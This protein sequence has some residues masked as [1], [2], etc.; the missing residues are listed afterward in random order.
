MDFHYRQNNIGSEGGL[1][2]VKGLEGL[3]SLR[4]VFIHFNDIDIPSTKLIVQDLANLNVRAFYVR[5]MEEDYD[6]IPK[7]VTRT[8]QAYEEWY[9]S[10]YQCYSFG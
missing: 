10:S 4:Y 1:R 2:V 6:D 7:N 3:K 5:Y 8:Q 9:S